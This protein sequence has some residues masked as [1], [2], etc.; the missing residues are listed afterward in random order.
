MVTGTSVL[1]VK[2][3]EGVI[4]AADMLG[5]YGSL[6][7][8]CNISRIMKVKACTMLRASG[9]YAD[10]QHLKQ[11]LEQ[12][13]IDK[14]LFGDGHNYSS[15]AIHSWLTRVMYNL[16]CKMNS[17]WNTGVLAGFYNGKSFLGYLDKLGVSY[18]APA[19]EPTLHSR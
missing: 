5:S 18:K 2:F 10:Y 6:V 1:G 9:D 3:V 14:E 11:V 4:I 16:R 7:R 8:F 19:L 13:V 17:L 15:K 12:M